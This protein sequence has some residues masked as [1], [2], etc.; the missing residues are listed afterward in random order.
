MGMP[1]HIYSN[2]ILIAQELS[3]EIEFSLM[4]IFIRVFLVMTVTTYVTIFRICF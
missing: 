2:D 3:Q 1:H 4:S